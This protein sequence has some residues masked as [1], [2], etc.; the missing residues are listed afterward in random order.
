MKHTDAEFL[1]RARE[2][3]QVDGEIEFD[4]DAWV[5]QHQDTR[6]GAYVQAWVWVELPEEDAQ[7]ESTVT[8]RTRCVLPLNHGGELHF[9]QQG[10]QW[11][12]DPPPPAL[13]EQ[14][15]SREIP[16]DAR[17]CQC[18]HAAGHTGSHICSQH[19]IRWPG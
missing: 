11:A 12:N 15:P 5:S 8:P 13:A 10:N 19:A 1:A 6:H 2:A 4:N 16:A 3:Y 9:A 17:S 7:C 18:D 14:C